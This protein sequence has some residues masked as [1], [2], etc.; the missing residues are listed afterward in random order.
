MVRNRDRL[1]DKVKIPTE[2]DAQIGAFDQPGWRVGAVTQIAGNV[3][4]TTPPDEIPLSSQERERHIQL[5]LEVLTRP[6]KR[7]DKLNEY[8]QTLYSLPFNIETEKGN[9]ELWPA[10]EKRYSDLATRESLQLVVLLGGTGSG[11]TGALIV[12]EEQMAHLAVSADPAD[13]SALSSRRIPVHFSLADLHSEL[14][15]HKVIRN[16][17]NE[18][19]QSCAGVVRLRKSDVEAMLADHAFLFLLDDLEKIISSIQ[20]RILLNLLRFVEATFSRSQQFVISC[21]LDNYRGQL[22]PYPRLLLAGLDDGQIKAVI[23]P[24]VFDR[25]DINFRELLRNRTM[26]KDFAGLL[27]TTGRY[28]QNKG[29][30][31]QESL[32]KELTLRLGPDDGTTPDGSASDRLRVWRLDIGVRILA[33]LAYR[34]RRQRATT[35]DTQTVIEIISDY[36]RDWR[37]PYGWREV[38]A[39]LHTSE[40]VSSVSVNQWK[41][42][43]SSMNIAYFAAQAIHHSPALLQEVLQEVNAP[44]WRDVLEIYVGLLDRPNEFLLDLIERDV[45]LALGCASVSSDEMSQ[46]VEYAASDALIEEMNLSEVPMRCEIAAEMSK[47]PHQF[48]AEALLENLYREWSSQVV[49]AIFDSLVVW[50]RRC[51]LERLVRAEMAC[52]AARFRASDTPVSQIIAH[53][54]PAPAP[55][56]D[57]DPAGE[58]RSM[59]LR[60]ILD[61]RRLHALTRG[62]AAIAL[63]RLAAQGVLAEPDGVIDPLLQHF[64]RPGEDSLVA[65]CIA[66]SLL[67]VEPTEKL[68]LALKQLLARKSDRWIEHRA[69]VAY[70]L[71]RTEI[72]EDADDL[73]DKLLD[74]EKESIPLVRGHAIFSIALRNHRA[75]EISAASRIERYLRE[76]MDR[77]NRGDDQ[78]PVISRWEMEKIVEALAERGTLESVAVLE[79]YLRTPNAIVRRKVHE[80]IRRIQVRFLGLS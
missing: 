37:E 72:V 31:V 25:L 7:D 74:G 1:I 57:P 5:Y 73:L 27:D 34:V 13:Q 12:L 32:W 8:Q 15:P 17:L 33:M 53:L 41:L 45:L 42:N 11:R 29:Q 43:L 35:L 66:E 19:L 18:V 79:A 78:S 63:S 4:F 44:T 67:K 62:L 68:A 28:P 14:S 2:G 40:Y 61:N 47:H 21:N 51:G 75:E 38:L 49:A 10:I 48:V 59:E 16:R 56:P 6:A 70:L 26:L 22:D 77:Q 3:T 76:K 52:A 65:W 24:S 39:V 64:T 20:P 80:T 30:L 46:D 23:T 60:A 50:T 55:D 54:L 9:D 69:R 71:G 58:Q 36:L